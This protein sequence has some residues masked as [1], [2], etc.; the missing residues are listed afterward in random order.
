MKFHRYAGVFE[1]SLA[2]WLLAHPFMQTRRFY[3]LTDPEMAE[4]DTLAGIMLPHCSDN[5]S[6]MTLR[7]VLEYSMITGV[8]MQPSDIRLM[9]NFAG[10]DDETN[11]RTR[12]AHSWMQWTIQHISNPEQD[13]LKHMKLLLCDMRDA[14]EAMDYIPER[15]P[16]LVYIGSAPIILEDDDETGRD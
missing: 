5:P 16:D 10:T 9:R 7:A 14:L 13:P 6:G 11:S 15:W 1:Y 3:L 12:L 4:S 2:G 8:A